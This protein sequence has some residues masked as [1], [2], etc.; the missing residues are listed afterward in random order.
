MEIEV[1]MVAT[2]Q[3]PLK[4]RLFVPHRAYVLLR[5]SVNVRILNVNGCGLLHCLEGCGHDVGAHFEWFQPIHAAVH[6]VSSL[7]NGGA[8]EA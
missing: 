5:A 3:I 6:P 4:L 7:W 1:R 8:F 2:Y